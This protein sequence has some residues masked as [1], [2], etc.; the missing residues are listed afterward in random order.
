MKQNLSI[1]IVDKNSSLKTL[2]VK[3]FDEEEL[4]VKC[5]FRKS[6]GFNKQTEWIIKIDGKKY[7]VCVYGK[8]EGKANTENKYD[9]PPPIDNVLFFGSCAIVSMIWNND[10]YEY[11][12]ITVELWEQMYEKL[13]G[14]FEN[15]AISTIE[16][17]EEEDELDNIPIEKKT[18]QGYLKDGFVVDSDSEDKDIYDSDDDEEEASG[19]VDDEDNED[20]MEIEDIGSE[21]SEDE[22]SDED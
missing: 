12:N 11:C 13:F 18:K 10:K 21:L 2:T 22:Y 19:N 1:L 15:L 9:F 3:N 14:G 5:G 20:Q 7:F 6:A 17:E 4:Y 16:D 8:T